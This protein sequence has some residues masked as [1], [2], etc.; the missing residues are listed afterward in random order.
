MPDTEGR[1]KRVNDQRVSDQ[2]DDNAADRK[3]RRD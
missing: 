2:R 3:H 1:A